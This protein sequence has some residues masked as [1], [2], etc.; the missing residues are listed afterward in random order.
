M[1]QQ[2]KQ[3]IA[4]A[5][6]LPGFE[7]WR[8]TVDVPKLNRPSARPPELP[9]QGRIAAVMVLMFPG[10]GNPDADRAPRLVLTKRHSNL[11]KHA[12]QISLPGGRQFA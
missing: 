10:P 3:Q 9:G 1:P 2:S 8:P 5:L 6:S 11:S 12:G 4:A 7:N